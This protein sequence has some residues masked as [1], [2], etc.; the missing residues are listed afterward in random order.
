MQIFVIIICGRRAGVRRAPRKGWQDRRVL[1][2][3]MGYLRL[4]EPSGDVAIVAKIGPAA[5]GAVLVVGAVRLRP[6]RSARRS[7]RAQGR[8]QHHVLRLAARTR[9][10]RASVYVEHRPDHSVIRPILGL[11]LGLRL[12]LRS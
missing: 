12:R 8:V 9:A 2:R 11:I 7:G 5:A 6:R 4:A 10:Q 3:R 1:V